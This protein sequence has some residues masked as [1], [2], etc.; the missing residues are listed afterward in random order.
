MGRN[1]V[2]QRARTNK[3]I[4]AGEKTPG[5]IIQRPLKPACNKLPSTIIAANE[6]GSAIQTARFEI[7]GNGPFVRA[8]PTMQAKMSQR[9]TL[10]QMQIQFRMDRASGSAAERSRKANSSPFS[11]RRVRSS[12]TLSSVGENMFRQ[13]GAELGFPPMRVIQLEVLNSFGQL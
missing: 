9:P 5:K 10:N 13:G 4:S 11:S 8:N 3:P 2:N 7:E 1:G 6:T 12:R